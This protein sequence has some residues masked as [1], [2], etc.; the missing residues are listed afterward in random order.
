[1][2]LPS[3]QAPTQNWHKF[4]FSKHPGWKKS[5]REKNLEISVAL[6]GSRPGGTEA[7]PPWDKHFK[8]EAPAPN[9]ALV[10]L[11]ACGFFFREMHLRGGWIWNFRSKVQTGNYQLVGIIII[12]ISWIVPS[13][14]DIFHQTSQNLSKS[15][16]QGSRRVGK[17]C[18]EDIESECFKN[19]SKY[20]SNA[21]VK[22]WLFGFLFKPGRIPCWLIFLSLKKNSYLD[23]MPMVFQ[24]PG[25]T[26]SSLGFLLRGAQH[27]KINS[28]IV[29]A[30]LLFLVFSS[31][32]QHFWLTNWRESMIHLAR[33]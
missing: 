21:W 25:W 27:C 13:L 23:K 15:I 12:F 22:W 1:M 32:C 31:G 33:L 17:N 9:G 18:L 8:R 3:S 5:L 10:K 16:F 20:V 2:N 30:D 29:E 28:E 11:P 4:V 19:K 24:Y 26:R 7:T 6:V 14:G